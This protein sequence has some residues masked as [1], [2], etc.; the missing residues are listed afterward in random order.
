MG[1][2]R[3]PRRKKQNIKVRIHYPTTPEGI[4]ELKESQAGAMLSILEERFGSDGL[5]Y[6]MEELK[7][8]IGYTQ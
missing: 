1:D 7:K 8:K 6:V 3:P 5:D 4:E 2:L